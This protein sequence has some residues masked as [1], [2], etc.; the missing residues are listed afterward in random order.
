MS[1][2][3]TNP[4]DALGVRKAPMSTVPANVLAEIGVAMLEGAAK[5]GRHNYRAVGVRASVYY[6]ALMRH[7]FAWWEGED[8]DPDSG[9]SHVTKAITTLLVLRD[10]MLNGKVEDDRPPSPR[11]FYADL[12]SRAGA[13]LDKYAD[14]NP[15][16]YTIK[17]TDVR[18]VQEAPTGGGPGAPVGPG[19]HGAVVG[20]RPFRVISPGY[21]CVSCS[22]SGGERCYCAHA[23]GGDHPTQGQG[24]QQ[25]GGK[26]PGGGRLRDAE[27]VYSE[28]D[29]DL[30]RV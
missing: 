19:R 2:K 24:V 15:R 1:D 29:D 17:D 16:H 3:P 12:N 22:A 14:K 8:I 20:A 28:F 27:R 4:K 25:A 9:V 26:A 10:A 5:Y 23:Q 30:A 11:E 21:H 6:D 7:I 18:D 13:V